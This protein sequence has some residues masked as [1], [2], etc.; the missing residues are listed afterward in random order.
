MCASRCCITN[1]S[2]Q[3]LI[4]LQANLC[5]VYY[6]D[7]LVTVEHPILLKWFNYVLYAHVPY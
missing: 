5:A 7:N 6:T 2:A 3:H 1:L 4:P